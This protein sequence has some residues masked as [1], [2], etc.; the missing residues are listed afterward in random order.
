MAI[1][2]HFKIINSN[3]RLLTRIAKSVKR[4]VSSI[5]SLLLISA[6]GCFFSGCG[7]DDGKHFREGVIEYEAKVIDETNNLAGLAPSSMTVKFKHDLFAA[8]MSTMG[9]FNTIFISNPRNK[10]LTQMVK[11]F[12]VKQACIDDEKGIRLENNE[13]RVKLTPTNETKEIA[14]FLCKKVIAEKEDDP[15]VKFDVYYTEELDVKNPNFSNPYHEINGMLME[16]RLKKFGLEMSFVAK[17]VRKEEVPDNTF[18]LPAYFK[19]ISKQE[20]T[21]FFKSIQ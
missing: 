2:F 21:E 9:V 8:E 17:S 18:E 20:M 10:T 6:T 19:V 5:I 15:S 4:K 7:V 1:R 13:Y 11:V 12:D 3:F 14:G 16:Y